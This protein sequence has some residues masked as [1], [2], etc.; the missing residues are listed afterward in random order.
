[1]I[2]CVMAQRPSREERGAITEFHTR[3]RERVYPPASDM[4]MMKYTLEMENLAIDWTSRCELRYP[5]P[6]LNPLFSGISLNHA[7]F[8]GDQPSLRYIA[9]EWYEEMKNYKYASNSCTGRCD[10]YKQMVHAESTELGC[11]VAQ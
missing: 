8:V 11:W 4:R 9:Q 1:M 2:S 3:V 7:V 10:H 6:A 5:D